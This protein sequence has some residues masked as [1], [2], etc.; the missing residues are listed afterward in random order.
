MQELKDQ[1][2][3]ALAHRHRPTARDLLLSSAAKHPA[4]SCSRAAWAA[5]AAQADAAWSRGTGPHAAG[6]RMQP[7]A[8]IRH[9][10]S[11]DAAGSTIR[12]NGTRSL[13]SKQQSAL[14]AQ[15]FKDNKWLLK[16][17]R[18]SNAASRAMQRDLE[19]LQEQTDVS[20]CSTV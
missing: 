4:T 13:S 19:A 14:V 6:Q 3:A 2:A 20:A 12:V 8:V 18:A 15:L 11:G 9:T 16:Q 17:L 1:L 10:A 7:N 5:A